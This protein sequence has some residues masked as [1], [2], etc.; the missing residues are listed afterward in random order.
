MCSFVCSFGRLVVWSFGSL[1]RCIVAS[2]HR[3]IVASL[4]R[5]IVA[6][7]HRCIVASLHRCIIAS[8]HRCI[9]GWHQRK[10]PHCVVLFVNAPHAECN[11]SLVVRHRKPQPCWQQIEP[12]DCGRRGRSVHAGIACRDWCDCRC[13]VAAKVVALIFRLCT[14]RPY[15]VFVDILRGY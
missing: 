12:R 8:L 11:G 6:S 1:R 14:P 15:S 7:L 5:C 9:V 13:S 4:H 3:C 10:H 2:L